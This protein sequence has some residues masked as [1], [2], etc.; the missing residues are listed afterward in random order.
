MGPAQPGEPVYFILIQ[1]DF[2]A[3][4]CL[5]PDLLSSEID[6]KIDQGKV[7]DIFKEPR[8]KPEN[9]LVS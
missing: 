3:I 4:A 2:Q 7:L 6:H 8:T 9:I 1:M 5:T